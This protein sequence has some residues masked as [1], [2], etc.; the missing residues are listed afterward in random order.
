MNTI[1]P[2]PYLYIRK[3]FRGATGFGLNKE[4]KRCETARRG[5]WWVRKIVGEQLPFGVKKRGKERERARASE[6]EEE[7]SRDFWSQRRE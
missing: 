7:E 4:N 3:N 1:T 2:F 5:W 6:G